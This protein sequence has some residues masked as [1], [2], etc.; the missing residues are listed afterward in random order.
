MGVHIVIPTSVRVPDAVLDRAIAHAAAAGDGVQVALPVVLPAAL[1]INA[2][3]PR[4]LKKIEHQRAV[5]HRALARAGHRGRVDVIQ[6][7]SI[8]ALARTLCAER[9]PAELVLAGR[10]SWTFRR[11]L[12]A[13]PV[14][15]ISDRTQARSGGPLRRHLPREA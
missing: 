14:T 8:A 2:V 3:P 9:D 10:A 4:L 1:P 5:V 13:A 11:V 12:H 15:V 7:H 6:C